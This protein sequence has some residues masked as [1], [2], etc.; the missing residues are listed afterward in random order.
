[1]KEKELDERLQEAVETVIAF[2]AD[3]E[4]EAEPETVALPSP[5]STRNPQWADVGNG[6]RPVASVSESLPPGMYQIYTTQEGLLFQRGKLRTDSLIRFQDSVV[7]DVVSE[8]ERFW[9][10]ADQFKKYDVPFKRGILLWGP[11]GSGK[12][13]TV[14]L[15]CRDLIDRGG[16][17]LIYNDAAVVGAAYEVIRSIQ[18]ETPV[19]ILMEDIDSILNTQK[20]RESILLNL[21]DGVGALDKVLFLA[22]TNYP[23]LLGSR[24]I[25]RPSRFDKRFLVPHPSPGARRVYVETMV[26]EG[27]AV[28]VE[29]YVRETQGLSLAHLKELFVSTVVM[30]NDFDKSVESI[31]GL[32][33]LPTS[34]D[35]DKKFQEQRERGYS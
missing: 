2:M 31:K 25:N 4:E 6:F 23:E 8:V 7:D 32:A 33:E 14:S 12:S 16:I 1:M 30:G 10:C 3:E 28:D 11:P 13:C 35:E 22:T 21:L 15:V 24:I 26:K 9:S 19:V 5:V 27:D 17:I 34:L 29:R 18:P 20:N